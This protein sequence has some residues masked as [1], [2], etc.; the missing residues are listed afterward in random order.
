MIKVLRMLLIV[1]L[2]G[3]AFS[4]NAHAQSMGICAGWV[5]GPSCSTLIPSLDVG[6]TSNNNPTFNIAVNGNGSTESTELLV[7]IP[8]TDGTTNLT[9]SATFTPSGG[10]SSVMVAA[11]PSST[12][13]F[14]MNYGGAT[15]AY[16]LSSYLG[17]TVAS[18][19][20]YH[21][22]SINSVE[23][24]AGNTGFTVYLLT[25]DIPLSGSGYVSVSFSGFSSGTGFPVGTIMLAL[26][27]DANGQIIYNT[28]LT[29]GLE[30]VGQVPEPMSL[31]LFGTGLLGIA[32]LFR[33]RMQRE[34]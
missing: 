8:T 10:G 7:L 14:T 4:V 25:T 18:G 27:N 26:G 28:P 13:P 33:R 17:L 29:Q 34:S 30:D 9:F 2:A 20:D 22:S 11:M 1:G 15:D 5:P 19:Q 31:T 21:F 24:N 12:T 6:Q 32:L 3:F 23:N 16:L